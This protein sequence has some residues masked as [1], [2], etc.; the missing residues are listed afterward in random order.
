MKSFFLNNTKNKSNKMLHDKTQF[1]INIHSIDAPN[2][3]Y[4][5]GIRPIRP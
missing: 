3:R 5:L 2:I 1:K 4:I